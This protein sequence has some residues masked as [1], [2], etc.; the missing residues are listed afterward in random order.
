MLHRY[1]LQWATPTLVES[2]KASMKPT[3]ATGANYS[4]GGGGYRGT[5]NGVGQAQEGPGGSSGAYVSSGINYN[6][7]GQGQHEAGGG[8][9]NLQALPALEPTPIAEQGSMIA[10]ANPNPDDGVRIAGDDNYRYTNGMWF[11]NQGNHWVRWENGGW[12]NY[13]MN[14]IASENLGANAARVFSYDPSQTKKESDHAQSNDKNVKP[15]APKAADQKPVDK[16]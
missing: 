13:D 3:A 16:K 6:L 1:R 8:G 7:A 4:Y 2:D 12:R 10:V 14:A 15:N 9:A 11:Y 5:N